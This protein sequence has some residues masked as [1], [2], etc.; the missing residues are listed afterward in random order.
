[1]KKF[2]ESL[3]EHSME[4][5]NFKKK[6]ITLVTNEEHELRRWRKTYV[7]KIKINHEDKHD[8]YKVIAK[9]R[10]IVITQWNVEVLQIAFVV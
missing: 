8:Q 1:M 6:K 7:I 9:L 10:T 2:F 3:R 4:M 5:T